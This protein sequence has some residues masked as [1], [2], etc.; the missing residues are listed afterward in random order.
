MVV[1]R[2]MQGGLLLILFALAAVV[3]AQ[4][5]KPKP[6]R[7]EPPPEAN[8]PPRADNVP[9]DDAA[10]RPPAPPRPPA[11]T[12]PPPPQGPRD[13]P[14][15]GMPPRGQGNRYQRYPGP[16]MPQMTPYAP[17]RGG[18][19]E[20]PPD[21]PEMRELVGQDAELERQT[22]QTAEQVRRAG[23]DERDRL[24]T[25]LAELVNKHFN[26]RQKRRELQ[27]KRMEDELKRLRDA[28]SQRNES[29]G[30]IVKNR[31][32]ELVGDPQNL[33]F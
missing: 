7:A 10:P 30:S 14:I 24:K 9:F 6:K 18:Y 21:D 32:A 33:E 29:R 19:G 17:E 13:M 12:A 4:E 22:F 15:P 2:L 20:M 25:Q 1:H 28:I 8:A 5:P 16:G 3:G 23:G 26:V 31:L 11:S 27:L